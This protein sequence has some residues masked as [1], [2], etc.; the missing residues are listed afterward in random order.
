[1]A[2]WNLPKEYTKAEDLAKAYE[3]LSLADVYFGRIRRWQ[4]YRFY[5]YIY[6]LLSVE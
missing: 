2:R 5:V 4:Y 6:N 3:N 1:M